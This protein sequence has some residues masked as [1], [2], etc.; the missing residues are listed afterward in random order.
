M[1][2]TWR[3]FSEMAQYTIGV[4]SMAKGTHNHFA[5]HGEESREVI[6]R[7]GYSGKKDLEGIDNEM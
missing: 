2:E 7:M 1:E 6:R 5:D 4:I 3:H